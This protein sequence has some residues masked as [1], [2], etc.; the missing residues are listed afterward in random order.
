MSEPSGLLRS[1]GFR[2]NSWKM[3]KRRVVR[4]CTEK[5]EKR[6]RDLYWYELFNTSFFLLNLFTAAL[7]GMKRQS[8]SHKLISFSYIVFLRL[9]FWIQKV[10]MDS[11]GW[12]CWESDP[13]A[14]FSPINLNRRA[15][16]LSQLCVICR[17][18]C[19]L[20]LFRQNDYTSK[21]KKYWQLFGSTDTR[22][23]CWHWQ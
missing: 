17:Q 11:Q 6:Q 1:T 7:C 2:V 23:S 5:T 16:P 12:R 8:C 20:F 15:Q 19:F 10:S 21:L 4:Q 22:P 14:S 3:K 13:H 9:P 18:L